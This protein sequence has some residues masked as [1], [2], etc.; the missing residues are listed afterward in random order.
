MLGRPVEK[1]PKH[2]RELE[3]PARS[4]ELSV[5]DPAAQ[6]IRRVLVILLDG[7]ERLIGELRV[8]DVDLQSPPRII[9]VADLEAGLMLPI[10]VAVRLVPA[11]QFLELVRH[12]SLPPLLAS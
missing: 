9:D 10:S 6:P 1:D 4:L 2:S 12:E 8:G 5:L 3:W 7:L 11:L